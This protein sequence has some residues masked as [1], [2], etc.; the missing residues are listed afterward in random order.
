[1]GWQKRKNQC[2]FRAR[3]GR[4]IAGIFICGIA[5][6]GWVKPARTGPVRKPDYRIGPADVLAISVWRHPELSEQIPVRPDGRITLPLIGDL[7]ASGK[8]PH[9]LAQVITG[10]LAVY[11]AQPRVTVALDA[12]HSRSFNVLGR[13]IHPGAFHLDRPLRV[14]DAL[15]M[16]G[17][18][19]PFAH[20]DDL[21][22]LRADGRGRLKRLPVNYGALILG[23][24][25]ARDWRLRPGDTVVVP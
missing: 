14:L 10:K 3:M 1:M 11:L 16:A 24:P 22:I 8:T 25:Q 18:F 17:G 9:Q 13:V 15:A 4:A 23:S 5:A 19:A 21:Y 7:E 6:L 20:K 2:C 12:V